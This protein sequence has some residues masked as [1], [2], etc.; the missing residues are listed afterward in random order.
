MVPPWHLPRTHTPK[1]THRN[2]CT[3]LSANKATAQLPDHLQ[4][5][6]NYPTLHPFLPSKLRDNFS[7]DQ[8]MRRSFI[9]LP[10]Y[11]T[12]FFLFPDYEAFMSLSNY[13]TLSCPFQITGRSFPFYE[14]PAYPSKYAERLFSHPNYG[15]GFYVI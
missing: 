6:R 14:I 3:Y 4:G 13:G 12:I 9:F 1:F 2:S 10:D 5:W 15:E 7:P 11:W 8:I